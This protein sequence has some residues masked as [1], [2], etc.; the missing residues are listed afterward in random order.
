LLRVVQA[1]AD[2][3]ETGLAQTNPQAAGALRTA[4][5]HYREYIEFRDQVGRIF[6]GPRNN[7]VA[8]ETAA[9]RLLSMVTGKGD[10]SRFSRIY[11]QLEPAERTDL[12]ATIVQNLG[13]GRNGEFSLAALATNT[14]RAN[15]RALREALGSD[16]FRA[17]QDLRL[18]A[19]AKADTAANL[20][21]SRTGVVSARSQLQDMVAG[22]LG[23]GAAGIPGMVVGFATRRAAEGV[24]NGRTSRLLLNPDFTKWMRQMPNTSN[25]R[26][27]QAHFNRLDRIAASNAVVA[28][29]VRSLQ[30]YLLEAFAQSPTRA[31]ATGQEE[32]D[33]R[34]IPPQ[35]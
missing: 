30:Q 29:D 25:P 3:L 13:T 2:E 4:N 19:R 6:T 8:P 31:A 18:I 21:N 7:P 17:L 12:A 35:P 5:Q 24:M 32:Q 9:T 28:A 16:G 14:S 26:V 23:A 27:I 34:Q 22:G 15:Q 10:S 11:Q 1:A 33:R 20:N